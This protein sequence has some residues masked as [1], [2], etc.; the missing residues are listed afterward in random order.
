IP[1][2]RVV[3]GTPRVNP[4]ARMTNI[5]WATVDRA[6][7]DFGSGIY[8]NQFNEGPDGGTADRRILLKFMADDYA[9]VV[10]RL[11]A[12]DEGEVKLDVVLRRAPST[13]VTVYN[14]DGRPAANVDVG[15]ISPGANLRL[16]PGGI[17]HRLYANGGSL[18]RTEKDGTFRLQ[19]DETITRIIVADPEGYADVTPASLSVDPTI[20]LQPWGRLEVTCVSGGKPLAGQEYQ[21]VLPEVSVETVSF[22]FD[23]A[24]IQTDA[25]GQCSIA[26]VPPGHLALLRLYPQPPY[27]G[28]TS[29]AH[30][31]KTFFDVQSGQTTRLI[32]GTNHVVTARLRWPDGVVRDPQWSK[33]GVLHS[34]LPAM[35]PEVAADPTA[36]KA[37]RES[38]E[39][40]AARATYQ[41]WPAIPKDDDTVSVEDI[42]AGNYV[43]S[44]VYYATPDDI[45]PIGPRRP[46]HYLFHGI[47]NVTVPEGTGTFDAGSIQLQPGSPPSE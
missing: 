41:S 10:S 43:F 7:L 47:L 16:I 32:L 12:P 19:A 2:F 23:A 31:N 26:Q 20:R 24:R 46:L 29:W 45:G 6:W 5:Q 35:P 40:K 9:P 15:L 17:S 38:D 11:I 8:S 3:S 21:L 36:R 37:F 14:P 39:Y 18:L 44:V 33:G 34:L 27:N 22:E 42:P 30:G 28:M 4:V 25:N 1:H 13:A